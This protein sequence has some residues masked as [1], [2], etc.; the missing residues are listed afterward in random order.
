MRLK[1]V[2]RVSEVLHV[3]DRRLH[4]DPLILMIGIRCYN[5]AES[6]QDACQNLPAVHRDR[7]TGADRARRA[8]APGAQ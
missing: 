6:E 8:K 5:D 7:F 3:R 2:E 4:L 1:R